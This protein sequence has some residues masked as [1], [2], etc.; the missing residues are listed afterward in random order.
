MLGV[1]NIFP[2]FDLPSCDEDNNLGT[3]KFNDESYQR[4]LNMYSISI[5][6][7]LHLYVQQKL[8]KWIN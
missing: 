2:S 7:I 3:T 6:R 8:K 4:P 5:Q 1:G